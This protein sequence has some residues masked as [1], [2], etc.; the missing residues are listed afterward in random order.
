KVVL[1]NSEAGS[2]TLRHASEGGWNYAH[3]GSKVALN[4]RRLLSLDLKARVWRLPGFMRTDMTKNGGTMCTGT[5][6]TVR[7]S[8]LSPFPCLSLSPPCRSCFHSSKAKAIASNR[9]LLS[10]F[11]DSRS[12]TAPGPLSGRTPA[13]L[14]RSP[15]THRRPSIHPSMH[16]AVTSSLFLSCTIDC[17]IT[18]YIPCLA[19][20]HSGRGV[21]AAIQSN[22]S[23]AAQLHGRRCSL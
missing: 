12:S 4:I 19:F 16:F 11:D 17:W 22:E 9:T 23:T 15:S 3:H 2:I 20:R 10:S 14:C 5:R 1:I 7:L 13:A 18:E 8:V 6:A 21:A